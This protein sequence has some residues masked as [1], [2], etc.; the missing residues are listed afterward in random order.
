[1]KELII[2]RHAKSDWGTEFLRDID[3]PLGERG[4]RDAYT[5]CEWYQL[6]KP[7]PELIVTS[8]ATRALNTA[9][10]FQ[11]CLGL[12]LEQV[13][14]DEGIYEAPAE[15]ILLTL[16]Q[17]P[18]SASRIMVFGHNP[19]FTNLCN[20]LSDVF[21]DNVPTC[22]MVSYKHNGKWKDIQPKKATVN[23]YQFPKDFRSQP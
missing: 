20:Q 19:G 17:L 12:K 7:L 23:Y 16:Q 4:Y 9:L 22:G 15:K 11:R 6:H 8:P 14:I 18:E 5:M 1:M 21:F 2:T 3:R 13:K 10:I